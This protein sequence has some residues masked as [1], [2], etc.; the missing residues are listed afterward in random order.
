MKEELG[1]G[2]LYDWRKFDMDDIAPLLIEKDEAGDGERV[3]TDDELEE[4]AE[5]M[6]EN[7]RECERAARS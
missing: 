1:V 2:E 6:I 7:A 3:G 5:E 4:I